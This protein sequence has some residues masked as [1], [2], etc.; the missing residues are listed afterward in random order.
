MTPPVLTITPGQLFRDEGRLGASDSAVEK[1]FAGTHF[2]EG[3]ACGTSNGS[4]S[5]GEG[6]EN[7]EISVSADS[8]VGIFPS[9]TEYDAFAMTLPC[10]KSTT[11]EKLSIGT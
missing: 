8:F 9:F 6:N 11:A 3:A 4:S 1:W 7:E 10:V 5:R 2:R